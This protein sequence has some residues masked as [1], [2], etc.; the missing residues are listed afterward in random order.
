MKNTRHRGCRSQHLPSPFSSENQGMG[1][2]CAPYHSVHQNHPGN[3]LKMRFPAQPW[4]SCFSG[5]GEE[6]GNVYLRQAP[7]M[8]LVC[9]QVW[10]ALN[11]LTVWI[12]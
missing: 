6:P 11:L 7:L 2:L 8:T 9:G 5:F 4:R 12:Q 10:K 1:Q 3:F